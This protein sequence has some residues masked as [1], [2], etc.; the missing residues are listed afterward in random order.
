MEINI[1]ID[2]EQRKVVADGLSTVLA[3]TY[4]LY[5]K[6]QNFH[7]NVI[8]PHF[9]SLHLLFEKQYTELADAI[10]E[11]AERIRALGL[12]APGGFKIYEKL[13][14]ITDSSEE[15][16]AD[17]MIKTLVQDNETVVKVIKGMYAD[18]DRADDQPTVDLL[19]RRMEVHEKAAWML[20][21]LL[22]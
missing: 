18:A 11:I 16:P 22:E 7:W 6:T 17:E 19:T 15:T 5:L 2:A 20:R 9:T 3:N 13:A 8:G 1:G 12:V 4:A 14:T 21:S 10:D